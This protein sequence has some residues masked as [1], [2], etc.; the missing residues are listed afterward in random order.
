MS[1]VDVPATASEHPPTWK[2]GY[3]INHA[4]TR[5]A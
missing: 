1:L 4:E 3:P 2:F 5:E